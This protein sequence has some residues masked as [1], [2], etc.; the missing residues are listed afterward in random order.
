[1]NITFSHQS[2][3]PKEVMSFFHN[4]EGKIIVDATVGGG[5]HLSLL[6]NAVGD[7][8]LVI[9][10][11]R[12]LR[13]H[14]DDAAL[15]IAKLFPRRIRLFHRPFSRILMTL[16]N[17]GIQRID[18]IL[19]DL[20]VSSNQ[21]DDRT[22][23]FSFLADAPIDMRMD[24]ENDVSAY[25]WLEK[26]SEEEI[27][28]TLFT[29]GGERKSRAIARSIKK[30]WPLENSTLALASIVLRALKQKT[31]SRIHPATR[32]F[33]A[34]RMAVN[35]EVDELSSLLKALPEMLAKNG[36]AVFLSFHSVED[37][38]VKNAFKALAAT[39][40]FKI[41]TKKPLTAGQEE[42]SNNRRA[43]SAKL[44]AIARVA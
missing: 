26:T 16:K 27:A 7:H 43:K 40:D 24:I 34:I 3:M 32:T 36:V 2:V 1:M 12:D 8:G 33:Q 31:W 23:G 11:D 9:G 5:G 22:R 4:I 18:G 37:R 19:A 21:L 30:S 10:F 28:N 41:L 29:L 20:G 25:E 38:M 6:A 14:Q 17:E 13:A 39:K 42:L 15:K 35:H 44:R